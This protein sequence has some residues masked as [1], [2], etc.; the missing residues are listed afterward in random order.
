[1]SEH[2]T[3]EE[4]DGR[5]D[6]QMYAAIAVVVCDPKLRTF[7]KEADPQALR[8]LAAAG[9]AFLSGEPQSH[10]D[11]AVEHML[12]IYDEVSGVSGVDRAPL[13]DE[14]RLSHARRSSD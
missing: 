3:I 8:Q 5:V 12:Q 9:C 2:R 1:M 14:V 11:R 13:D 6:T 10:S 4:D 7:L